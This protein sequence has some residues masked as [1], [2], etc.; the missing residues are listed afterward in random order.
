MRALAILLC[1]G[2]VLSFPGY[3]SYDEYNDFQEDSNEDHGCSHLDFLK[4]LPKEA[5]SE[6]YK[7]ARD[8]SQSILE[9]EK[10]LERWAEKHGVEDKYKAHAEKH[11]KQ[12]EAFKRAL[13]ELTKKLTTFFKAYIKI[14][15]DK[16]IR[17]EV[18]P[19]PKCSRIAEP[20]QGLRNYT[21][22]T[23]YNENHDHPS[24]DLLSGLSQEAVSEYYKIFENISQTLEQL[25]ASLERWAKK[26]G[27]EEKYKALLAKYEKEQAEF[28]RSLTELYTALST[29][30]KEHVKLGSDKKQTIES[31]FKESEVSYNKLNEKQKAVVSYI[32]LV[33]SQDMEENSAISG[34]RGFSEDSRR[35]LGSRGWYSNGGF[36]ANNGKSS[37]NN[38]RFYRDNNGF[39]DGD[40]MEPRNIAESVSI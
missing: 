31:I 22:N 13:T 15:N 26:Y 37:A 16:R 27:V 40:E 14:G 10:S 23:S 35:L 12:F 1:I 34:N 20:L 19:K 36:Q 5:L 32:F 11:E 24:D 3:D 4:G 33:Y 18:L 30:I 28:A 17:L 7:I 21:I 25:E 2:S 38:G 9:M 6:Y 29:F 8:T 39:Q